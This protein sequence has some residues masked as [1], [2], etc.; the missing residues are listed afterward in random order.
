ML[1][2]YKVDD[3]F[4]KQEKNKHGVYPTGCEGVILEGTKGTKFVLQFTDPISGYYAS[5]S[6]VTNVESENGILCIETIGMVY[7]LSRV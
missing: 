6:E 3:A 2:V 5:Q 4:R 1:T 7:L